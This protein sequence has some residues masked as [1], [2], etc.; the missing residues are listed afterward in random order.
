MSLHFTFRDEPEYLRVDITGEWKLED[1]KRF[2]EA[3]HLRTKDSAQKTI[4]IDALKTN[5]APDI[6]SSFF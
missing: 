2:A 5:T 3:V 4:F 1:L 6:S